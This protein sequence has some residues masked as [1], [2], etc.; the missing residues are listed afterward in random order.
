MIDLHCHMLP[1]IDDGS[2]S[3]EESLKMAEYAVSQG[4]RRCVLTPHINPGRYDNDKERIWPIFHLFS[5]KLQNQ[6]IPLRVFMGAEV[7][8][9]PEVPELVRQRMNTPFS[10]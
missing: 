1:C 8:L 10:E 5:R 9:C 4:I 7:R 2:K 6:R 3:M